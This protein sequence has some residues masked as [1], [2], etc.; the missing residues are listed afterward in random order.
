MHSTN[1]QNTPPETHL[2]FPPHPQPH[3]QNQPVSLASTYSMHVLLESAQHVNNAESGMSEHGAHGQGQQYG[4]QLPSQATQNGQYAS[5]YGHLPPTDFGNAIQDASAH[6]ASGAEM[7]PKRRKPATTTAQADIELRELL[8]RNTGRSLRDVAAEVI[9]AER[10]SR[11]E[12]AK[13]LFGMLWLQSQEYQATEG[14]VAAQNYNQEATRRH[15]TATQLDFNS[16]PQLPADTAVFPSQD[17]HS[18]SPTLS[19]L[20]GSS[21]SQGRL[22]TDPYTPSYSHGAQS[23]EMYK[24]TLKFAPPEHESFQDSDSIELPNIFNYVPPRTDVDAANALSALYRTHCTSLVDCVR[25]CKEKQFFRLFT[26]FYGT[27]TVPPRKLFVHPDL[28]PWIK[29]CDWLMYQKMIRF[30][31][32]LTLQVAPPV[33]LQ[34]LG[35]ISK[36][37]HGY[38]SQV[39]HGHPRHVLEAKLEPATLFAGLLH[40]MLRV[41]STAHAAAALLM[42]DQN[43]D[44]MWHDWVTLVNPKRIME[45]ELPDCGYEETYKILTQDV[46]SIL[47]PLNTPTWLEHNTHYQDAAAIA[48]ANGVG[49]HFNS[50]TVIDRI[51]GF[52]SRLPSRF[53]GASTRTLLHCISAIGTAA[54][55]EI[56]VENG[57]SFNLWWIT[58]VFVDEMSLWLASLGGFLDHQPADPRQ[59]PFHG[60]QEGLATGGN[61]SQNNSRYSSVGPDFSNNL[62]FAT[63]NEQAMQT[64]GRSDTEMNSQRL[65]HPL[66]QSTLPDSFDMDLRINTSHAKHAQEQEH[67]DSGIGMSLMEDSIELPKFSMSDPAANFDFRTGHMPLE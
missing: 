30:V 56:T 3:A 19:P 4:E 35:T 25:F 32:Q 16:I 66:A 5:V 41:N 17:Q 59:S 51:A 28:A 6:T 55:R 11:A 43:R 15:S 65:Q 67:D 37:L 60:V 63:N 50:D 14:M 36:R 27:L 52:L 38:I 29:E 57:N 26:S 54:I 7:D 8:T 58:K 23:S 44:L 42:T 31:S 34:F 13:Q 22:F 53:P 24:Q 40:R 33:V 49:M 47:Q 9:S 1:A 10:T 64:T 46:R 39:F 21:S 62:S 2:Q 48:N 20:E 45:S 18:D 61:G 12:K